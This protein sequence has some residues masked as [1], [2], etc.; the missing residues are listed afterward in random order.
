MFGGRGQDPVGR[1]QE[2]RGLLG[3]W[4]QGWWRW[5]LGGCTLPSP[6]AV[7]PENDRQGR[8]VEG[9]GETELDKPDRPRPYCFRRKEILVSRGPDVPNHPAIGH[10]ERGRIFGRPRYSRAAIQECRSAIEVCDRPASRARNDERDD[11]ERH[12]QDGGDSPAGH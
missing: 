2:L 9:R 10:W 5:T 7:N 8:G 6:S 4:T 1:E 3:R 11:E 12:E